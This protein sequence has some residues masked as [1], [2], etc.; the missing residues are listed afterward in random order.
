MFVCS[1]VGSRSC[2]YYIEKLL[3]NI[4]ALCI[5]FILRADGHLAA[6]AASILGGVGL[7]ISIAMAA[8]VYRDLLCLR[9][10]VQ[11]HRIGATC[12]LG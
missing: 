4:C 2:Y 10:H 11:L 12:P 9:A 6:A 7:S 3:A 8:L 5:E 1:M